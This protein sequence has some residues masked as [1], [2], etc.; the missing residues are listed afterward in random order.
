MFVDDMI[1]SKVRPPSFQAAENSVLTASVFVGNSN[2]VKEPISI[3]KFE[4][5]FTHLNKT[6]GFISE[7]RSMA[8][9]YPDYKIAFL[10]DLLQSSEW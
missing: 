6:L 7:S 1:M 4:C 3:N 10:L 9:S 5:F 2:L 8:A